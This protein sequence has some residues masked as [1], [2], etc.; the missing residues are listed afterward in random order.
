[1]LPEPGAGQTITSSRVFDAAEDR[2]CHDLV[3]A[4]LES[5]DLP[6]VAEDIP[7][8]EGTSGPAFLVDPL[9]GT[10]NALMGYPAFTSSVALCDA[11]GDAVFG[12][13]YDFS[14]DVTYLT[15]SGKGSY[16][17]S[18]LTVRRLATVPRTSVEQLAVSVMRQRVKNPA[19]ERLMPIARKVRMSGCS[20]FD[21]CLIATGALDAF[22]DNN[23]PG[24]E[25]SCDIAAAALVLREAGGILLNPD[26]TDRKIARPGPEALRDYA[27]LVA[28]GDARCVP[29]LISSLGREPE[30]VA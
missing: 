14:R 4:R 7:C 8:P 12:W 24:H 21:L 25:R 13:V 10:H 9:D 19:L 28:V 5:F 26:G 3:H 29:S 16:L 17:Q 1:M 18:P 30:D 6:I 27:G 23:F 2:V 20:S 11:D 15:V 22:I